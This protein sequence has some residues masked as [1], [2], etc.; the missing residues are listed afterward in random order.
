LNAAALFTVGDVVRDV[1][2]KKSARVIVLR[3]EGDKAFCAGVDLSGG[4]SDF[5]RT[6]EGLDYCLTGLIE[7]SCPIISM[8]FGSAIGAGL[9]I[10]VISDFR[11]AEE[12]AKFGAPLV[13]LGR[14]Y[15]LLHSD[16]TF[17]PS[18]RFIR[19]QRDTSHRK[20]DKFP[21]RISD[22]IDQYSGEP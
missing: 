17:D 6:I 13:R 19:C 11:I 4:S 9:D 1:E 5:K 20:A 3:G 8:I 10:A 14:T 22:G 2:Q 18:Y 16:R 7:Y 12:Q 21:A 15:Y